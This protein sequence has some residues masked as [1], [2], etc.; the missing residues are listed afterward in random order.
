[1]RASMVSAGVFVAVKH[2]HDVE[3][4]EK[5][6]DGG[7]QHDQRLLDNCRVEN[8]VS[9]LEEEL[10]GD[11]P[12]DGDVDERSQRLHLLVAEGEHPRALLVALVDG[13]ER[14][15]I[16]GHV[17]EQVEGICEDG[18]GVRVVAAEELDGHED[19]GDHRDLPQFRDDDAVLT[20]HNNYNSHS[21]PVEHRGEKSTEIQLQIFWSLE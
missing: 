11:D 13:V 10:E 18:D 6:E 7:A 16:G 19:E 20:L 9:G 5:P 14:D 1:M 2:A 8:A 4:T 17:G 21:N 15:D 12:D 3:V